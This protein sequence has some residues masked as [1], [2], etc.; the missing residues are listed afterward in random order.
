MN[1]QSK[2][3]FHSL[4]FCL[5]LI[6]SIGFV[7]A[8]IFVSSSIDKKHVYPDE[9]AFLTTKV[10]ND[11]NM[12][13]PIVYLRIEGTKTVVF[14]DEDE[15]STVLKT[16]EN[17]GP[18]Q[19]VEIKLKFKVTKHSSDPT[20][21]FVY[22]G[23]QQDQSEKG[24]PFVSG[25]ITKTKETKVVITAKS[26]KKKDEAGE[27]IFIEME[28][29]NESGKEVRAIAAEVLA[30]LDFTILSDP[31]V[32]QTLEDKNSLKAR[33]EVLAPIDV[34]GD[35]TI[36]LG[37]G[38]FDEIGPHYFQKSFTHSFSKTDRMTLAIIGIIVL[39]AAVIIY[40]SKTK[41]QSDIKGTG[42]KK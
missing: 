26:E 23:E 2:R 1:P 10:F 15:K 3:F 5:I 13:L 22:Y 12:V 29:K 18:K 32:Q 30:P 4:I 28:M 11:A 9:V 7:N 41:G 33:F 42:E 34:D 31:F 38:Y 6:A 37:Y 25:T 21:I 20:P 36:S 24:L 8:E 14:I 16:V 27:K 39:I 17:L 19:T 35:Q 40:I